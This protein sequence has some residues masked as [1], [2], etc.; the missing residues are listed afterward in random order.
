MK[1][2]NIIFK[3]ADENSKRP[4]Q[5]NENPWGVIEEMLYILW[6]LSPAERNWK[7]KAKKENFALFEYCD[8]LHDVFA[9]REGNDL[10]VFVVEE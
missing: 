5:T 3:F 9:L 8:M 6:E 2:E 7:P 10:M 4:L 1:Y